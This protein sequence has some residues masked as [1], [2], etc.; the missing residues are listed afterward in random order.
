MIFD[1]IDLFDRKPFRLIKSNYCF[2]IDYKLLWKNCLNSWIYMKIV[3]NFT[4]FWHSLLGINSKKMWPSVHNII[5]LKHSME[6][7]SFTLLLPVY[8]VIDLIY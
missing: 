7:Q 1:L 6:N 8:I 5:Q 3:P 2:K 4:S